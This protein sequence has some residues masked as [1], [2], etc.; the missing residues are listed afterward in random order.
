MEA[1]LY[2]A[3]TGT[4]ER[5][6]VFDFKLARDLALALM[7]IDPDIFR[8]KIEDDGRTLFDSYES[9]IARGQVVFEGVAA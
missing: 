4:V 2:N 8:V 3:A 5:S 6:E 7:Q 9:M 1:H